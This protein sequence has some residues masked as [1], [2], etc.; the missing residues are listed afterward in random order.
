MH[1]SLPFPFLFL[2]VSRSAM[3]LRNVSELLD[4]LCTVMATWDLD[5]WT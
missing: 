5:V 4:L 3:V 2:S 1:F